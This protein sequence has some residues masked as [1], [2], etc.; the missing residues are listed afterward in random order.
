MTG[1]AVFLLA[2]AAAGLILAGSRRRHRRLRPVAGRRRRPGPGDA[3]AAWQLPV[4]VRQLASLLKSGRTPAAMWQDMARVYDPGPVSTGR[5]DHARPGPESH[6]GAH[7]EGRSLSGSTDALAAAVGPRIRAAGRAA[8]LGLSVVDALRHD[9]G[10][11]PAGPRFQRVWTELAACWEISEL[12]G[13]P[14]AV[15]LENF[16]DHLQHELDTAAAR[17][18][19]LAGPR[20]TSVL[21]TWLPLLGLGLG[22][23]MGVDPLG[24]LLGTPAGWMVLAAGAGLLAAGRMWSRRL[25]AHAADGQDTR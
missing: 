21:L 3:S 6:P 15:L 22:M 23:L 13:A 16:A 14:L 9:S 17:R 10:G 1:L 2:A 4:F 8:E 7:P 5:D 20:A 12:T 11:A 25:V 18:T 19:A 24:M